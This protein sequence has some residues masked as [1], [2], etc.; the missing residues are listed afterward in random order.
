[1]SANA[2]VRLKCDDPC[3]M[4]AMP[5]EFGLTLEKPLGSMCCLVADS[6]W[7]R[8]NFP[9]PFLST[10]TRVAGALEDVCLPSS[11]YSPHIHFPPT[12]FLRRAHRRWNPTRAAQSRRADACC[13]PWEV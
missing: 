3:S 1:M 4:V 10:H 6:A 5:S 12:S 9:L 11:K 13:S 2:S 7:H 8:A